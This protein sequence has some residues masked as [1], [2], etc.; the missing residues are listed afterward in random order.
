MGGTGGARRMAGSAPRPDGAAAAGVGENWIRS[1]SERF[2]DD[3]DG[4]FG[5]ALLKRE[6][7]GA[8]AGKGEEGGEAGVLCVGR[9]GGGSERGVEAG[10]EEVGAALEEEVGVGAEGG[11][12]GLGA[13]AEGDFGGAG[14]GEEEG[15]GALPEGREGIA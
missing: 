2:D 5:G 13:G 10:G 15:A 1:G 11:G 8:S 3:G 12:D 14:A 4:T 9:R 7:R 6:E